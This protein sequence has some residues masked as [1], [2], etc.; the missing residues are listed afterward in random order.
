[1][2][3]VNNVVLLFK[4]PKRLDLKCSHHKKRNNCETP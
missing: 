3:I 4:F 2:I 1:V